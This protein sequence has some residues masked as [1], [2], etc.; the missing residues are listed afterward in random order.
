MTFTT[1][2]FNGSN[3]NNPNQ[4]FPPGAGF[5]VLNTNATAFT[6]L[7]LG[8]VKKGSLT[9][10]PANG[11][12][13]SFLANQI[14]KA[15]YLADLGFDNDDDEAVSLHLWNGTAWV[16]TTWTESEGWTPLS[17]FTIDEEKGP[18]LTVGQ[19]VIVQEHGSASPKW[20]QT[21]IP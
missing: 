8:N 6:N 13:F 21:V 14:P 19:P 1:N 12:V 7:F 3:W 20:I 10:S 4:E 2:L 16:E 9:N 15:G 5:L 11:A 17:G 18:F